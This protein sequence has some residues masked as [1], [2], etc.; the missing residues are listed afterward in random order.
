MS[1]FQPS[2]PEPTGASGGVPATPGANLS[3]EGASK[4]RH[5]EQRMGGGR[6]EDKWKRTPN[7]T[8]RG[9]IHVKSFHCKLMGE[10]LEY[11]DQQIN[12]WL[13]AHPQYEVKFAT[14]T[15]GEWS[16]KIKEPNLVVQVWV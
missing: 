10:S 15:V 16:G 6:H 11:L 14:A 7:L 5:F 3:A 1:S 13:D 4:I 12:E 2:N 8:G 9:A